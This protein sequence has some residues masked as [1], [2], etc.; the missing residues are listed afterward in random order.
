MWPKPVMSPPFTEETAASPNSLF[1][2]CADAVHGPRHTLRYASPILPATFPALSALSSIERHTTSC[3]A[4][5]SLALFL[6]Q[7]VGVIL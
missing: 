3:T 2:P 5:V 6:A 7:V 1:R 4:A